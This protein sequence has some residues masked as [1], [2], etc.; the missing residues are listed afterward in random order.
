MLLVSS[1]GRLCRLTG[2][3]TFS[4]YFSNLDKSALIA[5]NKHYYEAK[6]YTKLQKMWQVPLARKQRLRELRKQRL[7]TLEKRLAEEEKLIAHDVKKGITFPVKPEEIFAVF[8]LA[9]TQYKVA[10]DDKVICSK[11]PFEVGSQVEFDKVLLI[12]AKDYTSIGRPYINSAKVIAS[13]E[14]QARSKKLII[15][16]KKRRKNYQRNKGHRQEVTV[17]HIDKIE[18]NPT[19]EVINDYNFL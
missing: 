6:E 10:R 14:E 1:V 17:L 15:Y 11:L 7:A 18:H 9:G 3:R 4:E 13:I 19:E 8:E 2:I 12:G 5:H 16:K